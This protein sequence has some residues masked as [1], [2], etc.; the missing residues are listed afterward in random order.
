MATFTSQRICNLGAQADQLVC[1]AV[2]D[3]CREQKLDLFHTEHELNMARFFIEDLLMFINRGE[4]DYLDC[5]DLHVEVADDVEVH[6]S[7]ENTIGPD[8]TRIWYVFQDR[9]E[10]LE[11]LEPCPPAMLK[12]VKQITERYQQ[13]PSIPTVDDRWE[14][15]NALLS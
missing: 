12:K 8:F 13:S 14:E 7:Y 3:R 11:R 1:E 6:A 2:L 5:Y 9:I 4:E 10:E 15:I